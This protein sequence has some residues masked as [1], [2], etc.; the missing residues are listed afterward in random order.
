[1]VSVWLAYEAVRRLIAPPEVTGGLALATAL[2][3]VVI[4]LAA[5]WAIPKANRTSLNVEGAYQHIL[6]DL[7]GFIATAVVTHA[8]MQV[9]FPLSGRQGELQGAL[10]LWRR[11]TWRAQLR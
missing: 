9:K 2:V 1:V 5:A 8:T 4:N 6:T 10:I 3:G 11:S 7:F